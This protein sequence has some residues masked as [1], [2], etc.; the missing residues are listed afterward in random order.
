MFEVGKKV[1]AIRSQ[2]GGA[3]KEGDVFECLALKKICCGNGV[4]MLID[5][6]FKGCASQ[7]GD[8]GMLYPVGE[9][10]FDA[11][12]FAPIDDTLSDIT[13]DELIEQLEIVNI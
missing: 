2:S 7:C 13:A 11:G 1:I 5:L 10:W 4:A 6:Y 9:A 3:F 12:N 8:C